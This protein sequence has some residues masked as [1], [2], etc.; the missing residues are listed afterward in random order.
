VPIDVACLR[1]TTADPDGNVSMEKEALLSDHLLLAQAASAHRGLS[2]VQVERTAEYASLGRRAFIP[3]AMVDC[4]VVAEPSKHWQSY[5]TEYN[6]SA[7]GEIRRTFS[8]HAAV[9]ELDERKVVA[10]RAA[11]ELQ[12]DWRVNLGIGFPE[13]VA[14]VA[15]EE[16]LGE[17]VTFSTEAGAYGGVALSGHDF[18]PAENADCLIQL[19]QQF[20]FYN[21]GGLNIC[22]LGLGEVDVLGNVNVTR[23]GKKLTGPGG[24]VDISQ[25]T[26]RVNLMGNFTAGA[27]VDVVDGKLVILK[28]G[29]TKKFVKKV[30]E[31]TF[32]G[33]SAITLKQRVKYIT[34]RCVFTLGKNAQTGAPEVVLSEIAPG[35]DIEK[36]ILPMMEFEPIIPAGG[37]MIMD[38]CIFLPKPMNLREKSFV[39]RIGDRLT[40]YESTNTLYVNLSHIRVSSDEILE[41]IFAALHSKCKTIGKKVD[42]IINYN[43]FDIEPD[44]SEEYGRRAEL[45]NKECVLSNRRFS[46]R[47]FRMHQLGEKLNIAE[48]TT[49]GEIRALLQKLDLLSPHVAQ[50][51]KRFAD[52]D[53]LPS[54]T[55][56]DLLAQVQAAKK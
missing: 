30:R 48:S 18:G 33:E 10:R 15:H 53:K 22:F 6:P 36:H 4:V 41:A 13:G 3:G 20:D 9:S 35:I 50:K 19:H 38:E 51:L 55:V 16:R 49:A 43:G 45:F 40:Y 52:S 26:H 34:E 44:F 21:G 42:M 28:E 5:V 17:F 37:P 11:M 47:A 24:F 25:A 1:G 31:I 23:L 27:E 8:K 54:R 29:K 46:S 7:T 56:D 39:P 14:K 32:S 2:I 12:S